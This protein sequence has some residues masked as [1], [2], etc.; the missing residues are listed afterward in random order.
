LRARWRR[1][2]G[3]ILLTLLAATHEPFTHAA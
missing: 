2:A 3:I 1:A